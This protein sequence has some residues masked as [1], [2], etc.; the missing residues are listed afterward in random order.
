M[1]EG[2]WGVGK[3]SVGRGVGGGYW[4]PPP[5]ECIFLHSYPWKINKFSITAAL[6]FL[7]SRSIV[8]SSR[9]YAIRQK[10]SC[11]SI[12]KI[13]VDFSSLSPNW[14]AL[15]LNAQGSKVTLSLMRSVCPLITQERKYSMMPFVSQQ[16]R[17]RALGR[18]R[19]HRRFLS[20]QCMHRVKHCYC[21]GYSSN[22][23][24]HSW[25]NNFLIM[26]I[27]TSKNMMKLWNGYP[28]PSV[29]KKL[30]SNSG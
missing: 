1:E 19:R 6:L 12:G 17:S 22:C 4:N 27:C 25:V 16:S 28:V 13:I 9:E 5:L 14:W 18:L 21:Y 23:F 15:G 3:K 7:P 2:R 11:R 24:H 26:R 10:W 20:I 29:K 30:F 8:S